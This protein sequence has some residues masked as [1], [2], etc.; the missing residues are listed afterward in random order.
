MRNHLHLP[1][2]VQV[3][4]KVKKD[5]RDDQETWTILT[6]AVQ[7]SAILKQLQAAAW[8]HTKSESGFNGL[9]G[10]FYKVHS[11]EDIYSC[12]SLGIGLEHKDLEKSDLQAFI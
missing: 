7:A 5:F 2:G 8:I 3:P 1:Q 6:D 12:N 9:M 10:L 4:V 11:I